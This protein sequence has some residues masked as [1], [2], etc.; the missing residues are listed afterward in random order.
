MMRKGGEAMTTE[1]YSGWV[2]ML[3]D[4]LYDNMDAYFRFTLLP[5]DTRI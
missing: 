1:R 4:I 2:Y 5:T 3:L